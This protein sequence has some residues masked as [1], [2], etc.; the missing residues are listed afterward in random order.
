MTYA[1]FMIGFLVLILGGNF[2]SMTLTYFLIGVGLFMVGVMGNGG[3]S[4]FLLM[5]LFTAGM[6]VFVLFCALI[7][8]IKLTSDGVFLSICTTLPVTLSLLHHPLTSKSLS[9]LYF[10][11][12]YSLVPLCFI[13]YLMSILNMRVVSNG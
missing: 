12:W 3:L 4:P 8:Q 10:S 11:S 7:Q 5:L 1:Y 13:L 2:L 9:I 6:L